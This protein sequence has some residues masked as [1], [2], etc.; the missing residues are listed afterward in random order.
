MNPENRLDTIDQFRGGAV[1]LMALTH[2]LRGVAWVPS[3]LD[4]TIGYGFTPPDLIAPMFIFAIGLTYGLSFRRRIRRDG[5]WPTRVHFIRRSLALI[6]LGFLITPEPHNWGLFQ[7]LGVAVFL[8]LLVIRLPGWVRLVAGAALQIGYQLL[9]DFSRGSIGY[10][11]VGSGMLWSLSW[12]AMLILATVL[13]DLFHEP[14]YGRKAC[15]GGAGLALALGFL[16]SFWIPVSEVW[17]TSSYV[18]IGLGGS[19]ILFVCFDWLSTRLRL[20]L[21]WLSAWGRNP[22]VLY[23]L[24][25]YLWVVVFLMPRAPAWHQQAPVWLISLQAVAF[26][27]VLT[28][29][30][31]FLQRRQWFVSM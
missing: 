31:W 23:V 9:L 16:V 10:E 11:T 28:G 26:I 4:N 7:T 1:I 19:G 27:G 25:Y 17:G 21:P 29:V 30:A 6:G 2:F 13:A 8:T 14:R 5:L 3:W 12:S 15:L 20:R 22:L 24:H 18:L